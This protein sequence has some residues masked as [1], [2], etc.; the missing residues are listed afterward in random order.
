MRACLHHADVR[1]GNH[2]SCLSVDLRARR[3]C[4][5]CILN[6]L[7][8]DAMI[9]TV[10]A[11]ETTMAFSWSTRF[12]ISACMSV[13]MSDLS[14]FS[15]QQDLIGRHAPT[16]S[17]SDAS[18]QRTTT[19]LEVCFCALSHAQKEAMSKAKKKWEKT[20]WLQGGSSQM[21]SN[22][23]VSNHQTDAQTRDRCDSLRNVRRNEGVDKKAT[24]A[25]HGDQTCSLPEETRKR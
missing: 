11:A 5:I 24:C 14:S 7:A 22:G 18:V 17:Q 1:C 15:K 8:R 19:L 25:L 3:R 9:S 12:L 21:P 2:I 16:N 20:H 13:K 23:P 6:I 10:A 4:R